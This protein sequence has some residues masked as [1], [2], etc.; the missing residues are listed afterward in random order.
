MQV[1]TPNLKDL[2]LYKITN[3]EKIWHSL[4][5]T[6]SSCVQNLTVLVLQSCSELKELFSSSVGV[7]IE[8]EQKM[9]QNTIVFPKLIRLE[10]VDLSKLRRLCSGCY[11]E[12]PSL[13]EFNIRNCPEM[14]ILFDEKVH[15]SQKLFLILS[16]HEY[17]RNI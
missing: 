2:N 13:E 14:T 5:P 9:P 15:Q 6:I 3:V 11:I 10:M 7:E 8:S 17:H 4:P 1:K 16:L 12:L